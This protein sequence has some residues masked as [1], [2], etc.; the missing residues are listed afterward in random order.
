MAN[1]FTDK[2]LKSLNRVVE[3]FKDPDALADKASEATYPLTDIPASKWTLRNRWLAFMQSGEVDNRGYGQWKKAGRNVKKGATANYILAPIMVPKKVNG[4]VVKGK[5]GKTEMICIGFKGINVFSVEDTE[6][7]PLDYERPDDIKNLPLIDVA[8]SWQIDV[9]TRPFIGGYKAFYSPEKE[10]IRL[11]TDSEKT[12]LHEL[13]HAAHDRLYKSAGDKL[14]G[15]QHPTQEIVAELGAAVLARLYGQKSEVR[16]DSYEYIQHYA[17][18]QDLD[19]LDACLKVITETSRV[20]G[21]IIE[22]AEKLQAENVA[23]AA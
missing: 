5:D 6:G 15:G 19:I 22:Q 20:V 12:F 9:A 16:K 10:C 8:R 23:V 4:Q 2:A 7:K 13:T 1:K 18:E 11:C 14:K 3:L 17:R 21:L